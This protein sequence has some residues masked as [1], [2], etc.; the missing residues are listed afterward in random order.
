MEEMD[1]KTLEVWFVEG[2]Q[3]FKFI[4]NKSIIW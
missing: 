3:H 4:S 1:L 2:S